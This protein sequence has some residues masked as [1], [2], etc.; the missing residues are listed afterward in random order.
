ME[1]GITEFLISFAVLLF[2]LY[3]YSI[4]TYD[5]WK[6]RKVCGPK[7]LPLMGNTFDIMRGRISLGDYV[8]EQYKKFKEEPF[9]G[10]FARRTP[11]LIVKDPEYIKDILIKDFSSFSDR[12]VTIYEKIEP[13]SQHLVNLD[14]A[15]WKSLRS[16]LSPVF[17]SGKLKEMFHLI[18]DCARH[19]EQ[20]L[21]DQVK[22]NPV[23]ECRE[24]TAKFT[25]DVIGECAFG[26][27]MNS[28]AEEDSEFRRIGRK[29]FQVSTARLIKMLVRGVT[30]W[31]YKLLSPIM[32]DRE[33]NDFFL[34][35]MKQTIA[36]RQKSETRRNDFVDLLIDIKNQPDKV[37]NIEITDSLITSQA[38]VFFVAGFETSS[39][40]MSNVLYELALNQNIQEE[41]REEILEEL[42]RENNEIRYETIK[43]MKYLH[44]V[45]CE[46]LRKYPPATI[47]MRQAMETYT[48]TGAELTIP[49]DTRVWIPVYAIQRDPQIYPDP[50]NFDPERFNDENISSRHPSFYL[51]FG[52][53][54]RNCIGARFANFQSKVGLVR[55]LKNYRVEV[56]PETCIPYV[57]SPRAFLLQPVGGIKL[58]FVKI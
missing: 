3:Y 28:L 19:F 27:N 1:F 46:T 26:L 50:E 51:P 38:F 4:G 16:K 44:K 7:P 47:L 6:N 25:T 39:T 35:L 17:T 49:K 55:V 45:F 41:V 24:L 2:G 22:K 5:F 43:N 12:G 40:T 31:L 33:V 29:V 32:Y 20:Y 52:D 21:D 54:P 11:I 57:N 53:G 37:G 18:V 30:P 56:C 34:N 9:I 15:R 13:L 14:F 36:H 23:I 10:I 8:T 58:R 48:F 42:Q